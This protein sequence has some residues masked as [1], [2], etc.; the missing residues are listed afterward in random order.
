MVSV[1]LSGA[2]LGAHT[3]DEL[4]PPGEDRKQELDLL[5]SRLDRVAELF[6][7]TALRFTCE[8]TISWTR[9]RGS[10]GRQQFGYV[11]TYKDRG[12]SR[13]TARGSASVQRGRFVEK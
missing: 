11:Y 8:E 1:T 5:L 13:I 4:E 7:D 3:T 12:G 10:S 6:L 2:F 9:E